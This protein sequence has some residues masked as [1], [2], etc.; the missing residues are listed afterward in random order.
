LFLSALESAPLQLPT[1]TATHEQIITTILNDRIFSVDQMALG[2]DATRKLDIVEGL[3]DLEVG[4]IAA[5]GTNA[6]LGGEGVLESR[7]FGQWSHEDFK[8]NAWGLPLFA[9]NE[10]AAITVRIAGAKIFPASGVGI[11]PST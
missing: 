8:E 7:P 5:R 4:G 6:L 1:G 11:E 10:D 2:A 9:G 3:F